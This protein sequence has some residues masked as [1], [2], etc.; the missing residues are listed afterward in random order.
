LAKELKN[1]VRE[2]VWVIFQPVQKGIYTAFAFY[3]KIFLETSKLSF[4]S[5]GVWNN[6]PGVVTALDKN[7]INIKTSVLR[8]EKLPIPLNHFERKREFL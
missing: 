1:K 8:G 2:A 5:I 3:N 6:F 7:S 4:L